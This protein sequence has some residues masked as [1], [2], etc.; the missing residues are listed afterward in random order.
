MNI[1]CTIPFHLMVVTLLLTFC[2]TNIEAKDDDNDMTYI[3]LPED[4]TSPGGFCMDGSMA[5]YY[6]R[7]GINPYLFVIHLRGGGGCHSE[8][9]CIARNGTEKGSSRLWEE[10]I[11]GDRLLD[12][13]CDTNP[14]FCDATAVHIPYCTGDAHLGNNT[15]VSDDTWGFYFDGHANFAAIVEHLIEE[16]ELGYARDVLLTGGSAGSVGAYFNVDWLASRLG[17]EVAVKGVPNAG[18]YNPGSLPGDLPSIFAPSDYDRFVAGE[19][20]NS[21]NDQIMLLEGAILPDRIKLKDLLSSE[22]LADFAPNEWW[23]CGS[24]HVAYHYIK[25]P[26]FNIHSQYD[27]NQ[28]FS[29]QGFAPKDPDESE[30]DSVE[31]Y[32]EMWGKATRASLQQILDNDTLTTKEHPDGLFSTSC[33]SHGTFGTTIDGQSWLPIVRDWFFDL[34][35]KTQYYRLMETCTVEEGGLE[36]PCN[37]ANHCRFEPKPEV[38]PY[39]KMCAKKMLE[40]ECAESYG[41]EEDCL[42]CAKREREKLKNAGCKVESV[43]IICT[44]AESHNVSK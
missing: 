15:E 33:L 2:G 37:P 22:C 13:N 34:G 35:Q 38:P 5:G 24:L 39:L 10:S 36:L 3:G 27:S 28:I 21:F 17:P 14:D 43:Q 16:F 12:G 41:D 32:I 31:S 40:L 4:I 1:Q 30:I 42:E 23:A 20:G 29:T 7:T 26:L 19:K 6:I 11:K 9:D 8:E 44:Y 25:S 18:W